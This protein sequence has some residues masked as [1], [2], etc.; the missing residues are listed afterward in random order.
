MLLTIFL[1]NSMVNIDPT[2]F[3]K[4]KATVIEKTF[5]SGGIGRHFNNP[6]FYTVTCRYEYD[7]MSFTSEPA[8]VR[9]RTAKKGQQITIFVDSKNPTKSYADQPQSSLPTALLFSLLAVTVLVLIELIYRAVM[10]AE[11]KVRKS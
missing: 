1:F 9:L 3:V 10:A 4:T 7:G 8:N 11:E 2:R 5:Y 6:D